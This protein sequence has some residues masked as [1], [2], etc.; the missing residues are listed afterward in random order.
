MG[1]EEST[2]W[3]QQGAPS[4]E[5][6]GGLRGAKNEDPEGVLT[7][8]EWYTYFR[9]LNLVKLL[10]PVCGGGGRAK[11]LLLQF[12]VGSDD[13]GGAKVMG[14]KRGGLT[15]GTSHRELRG[16]IGLFERQWSRGREEPVTDDCRLAEVLLPEK[17]SG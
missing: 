16:G 9:K 2:P 10:Q 5:S 1:G 17:R 8:Q 4:V 6:L 15:G 3:G 12:Q 11:R 14:L 7:R 13:C